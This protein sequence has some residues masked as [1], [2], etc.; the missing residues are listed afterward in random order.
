MRSERNPRTIALIGKF[1][2]PEIGESL[3]ALG[4][5]LRDRGVTVYVEE[6]TAERALPEARQEF[7]AA[8]FAAIGAQADVAIVLGGDGTMLNAARQLARFGVGLVGVNQG[9][10]GFMTDIGR[11]EMLSVME[12]LLDG[13]F[14]P[15]A[16]LMLDAE[17]YRGNRELT[18]NLALNDVVIDKGAIGRMIG[19]DLFID[20]E[21]I[22]TLRADGLIVTTPT[23]STA[24]SLSANGPIMHPALNGIG[25]VPL[26]PH[27]LSNRPV[28]VGEQSELELRVTH[29]DDPR[30]HFDGQVT[31][32]LR[33]GDS[34]RIRRSG[35]TIRFLHPPAYSY[36]GMLRQ[37]L[38]WSE[39]PTGN[40]A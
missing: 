33:P 26:C 15:E 32:D 2:S 6:A 31:C 27:A 24:Y 20:G 39:R 13:R 7:V 10:L 1:G 34:V 22:Y 4:R 36:F 30:L 23:G 12:E 17:I 19:L 14:K 28:L 25:L 40:S 3:V 9:T 37:K 5:F 35:Y 16:R 11:N 8:S 29:G 38:R 21:F 18:A